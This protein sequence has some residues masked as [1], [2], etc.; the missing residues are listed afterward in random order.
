MMSVS[1]VK[2]KNRTVLCALA[3]LVA[4]GCLQQVYGEGFDRKAF[5]DPAPEFSASYFWMWNDRLDVEKLC[6]QLEEMH[7]HGIRSVCVHPVPKAFRPA[8]FTTAMDATGRSER[9]ARKN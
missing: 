5:T 3:A 9:L 8:R 6:S 7:S 1:T 2:G 4:A